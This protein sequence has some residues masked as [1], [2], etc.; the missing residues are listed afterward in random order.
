L[1][2]PTARFLVRVLPD[3]PAAR[4][5]MFLASLSR[6]L[7][8]TADERDAVAGAQQFRWGPFHERVAL[9]CGSGPLVLLIHGWGGCAAQ[10]MPLAWKLTRFGF[11]V[12]APDI[13]GHGESGGRRISFR[14]FVNEVGMLARELVHPIHALVGHSAGGLTMMAARAAGVRA[15]H[16]VCLNAPRAPY[17]PMATLRRLLAPRG[18]VLERCRQHFYSQFDFNPED[19]ERAAAFRY[20]GQGRLL[21]VYDRDDEQVSHADAELIARNWPDV[22]VVKTSGHGHHRVLKS[23]VVHA[24]VGRFLTGGRRPDAGVPL[25]AAPEPAFQGATG[26][27]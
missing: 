21:L 25:T 5:T 2:I 24:E 19:L 22:V 8:L 1:L 17:P 9:E 7:P 10:M 12:V 16:Y 4:L 14:R 15:D 11:R 26:G 23:D 6:R 3:A 18:A 27:P 13:G 20:S